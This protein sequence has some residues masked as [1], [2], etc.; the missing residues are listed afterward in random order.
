M[1]ILVTRERYHSIVWH[2]TTSLARSSGQFQAGNELT[3]V[4]NETGDP[5]CLL[6]LVIYD[7]NHWLAW[8]AGEDDLFRVLPDNLA[9]RILTSAARLRLR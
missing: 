4:M 9:Y 5:D 2:Y 8:V 6:S 3:A 1:L 7:R